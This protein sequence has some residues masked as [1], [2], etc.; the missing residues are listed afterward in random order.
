M[1]GGGNAPTKGFHP[2]TPFIC[3]VDYLNWYDFAWVAIV[4]VPIVANPTGATASANSPSANA[5]PNP[6][7]A[8]N[9][10]TQHDRD[11]SP[12]YAPLDPQPKPIR[13]KQTRTWEYPTRE[14]RGPTGDQRTPLVRVIRIDDGQNAKP[15][16][17][18]EHWNG[19]KWVKGLQGIHRNN[20]PIYRHAEI[21]EAMAVAC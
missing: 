5:M 3:P 7:K 12:Y 14:G 19:T 15:K 1:G 4:P 10:P 13:P 16:R 11:G 6:P 21:Q 20:I 18:Q 17:W 2:F 9:S 8:E